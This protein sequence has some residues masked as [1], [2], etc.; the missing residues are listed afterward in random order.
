MSL[1]ICVGSALAALQPPCTPTDARLTYVTI[2]S[3]DLKAQSLPLSYVDKWPVW[4]TTP[5]G[6]SLTKLPDEADGNGWV[7]ATTFEQ[8]WL[9]I[10]LPMPTCRAAIGAVLKN[11]VPRYLFPAIESFTDSRGQR[12]HNRGL[13]SL[14]L[15]KTWLLFGDVPA[16]YLRLSC[17]RQPLPPSPPS[18][19][20]DEAEEEAA[21]DAGKPSADW[22]PVLPLTGVSEALETLLDVIANGPD[23]LGD[24]F[25]YLVAPL[26]DSETGGD[27]LLPT[28]A[29][30][31]GQR[32]RMFLSDVDA[33]PTSLD[34]EDR[35]SW[36][37]KRGETDL[38]LFDVAPGGESEFL[39]PVYKPLY[40]R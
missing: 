23:E 19:D 33:T 34:P 40:V 31:P 20:A 10:D 12:Y 26:R 8:F 37:W 4:I 30:A 7:T 1:L 36:V 16:D 3:A 25:C 9:P 39:P 15:A 27:V 5:D 18:S 17:Y 13:N 11:G 22:T 32:L 38:S 21:P 29:I 24:G 28:D 6:S 14:P 35:E 2:G